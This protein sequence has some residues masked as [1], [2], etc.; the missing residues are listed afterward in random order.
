MRATA[1]KLPEQVVEALFH[2]LL[3]D[4]DGLE[5][6]TARDCADNIDAL[7]LA[8]IKLLALI[9]KARAGL[10]GKET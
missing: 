9:A 6:T 7:N 4:L 10:N 8:A 1:D 5:D 3:S 2:G